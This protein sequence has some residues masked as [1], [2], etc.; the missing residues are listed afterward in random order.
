MSAVTFVLPEASVL[1][2][3][4]GR[5]IFITLAVAGVVFG[6]TKRC[7]ECGVMLDGEASDVVHSATCLV[8]GMVQA[9]ASL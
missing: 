8:P 2:L 4:A 6:N 7:P 1:A 5:A 9:R 3:N